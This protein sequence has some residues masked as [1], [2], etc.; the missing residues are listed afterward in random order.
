MHMRVAG[1]RVGVV[2]GR[3][4]LECLW[5]QEQYVVPLHSSSHRAFSPEC[6]LMLLSI[7][8][9]LLCL[10]SLVSSLPRNS[11]GW[12]RC[13]LLSFYAYLL[14][15]FFLVY[16]FIIFFYFFGSAESL[17]L[18][19][20]FSLRWLLLW[21]TGCR[22]RRATV[23][24]AC[25]LSSCG[26]WAQLLRGRWDLPGPGIEPVSSVMA[27]EFSSPVP[28]EKSSMLTLIR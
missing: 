24:A 10:S 15:L 16:S 21:S 3:Q 12:V 14:K 7:L 20:G 27:S 6:L 11:Q 4:S 22:Y 5:L 28:P 19:M 26:T 9:N 1:L 13:F 18:C 2:P 23:V 25:R 8:I 17:L